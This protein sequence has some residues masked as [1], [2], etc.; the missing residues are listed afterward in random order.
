MAADSNFPGS[1]SR[2]EEIVLAALDLPPDRRAAYLQTSC[3]D[4]SEL[5][6][7]VESM[8]AQEE[9]AETF[10]EAPA[11]ESAARALASSASARIEGRIAGPYR[12]E[13][14]IGAGGMGEVYRAVDTRLGRAVAL[15]FLAGVFSTQPAAVERFAREARAASALNHPNICTVYDV[16]EIEGLPFIAMEYLEGSTLRELL[17]EDSTERQGLNCR[18]AVEIA[19]AVAAGLASAHAK[20]ITHRDLKPENIFLTDDGRV[21]ILDFGLAQ[22]GPLQSDGRPENT[23]GESTSS[24]AGIVMGTVAYM[25]PEQAEGKKV[26]PRSDVFSFGSVL[27][28]LLTGDRPFRGN[29]K[30]D[31]LAA[32]IQA[33]PPPMSKLAGS[34]PIA[35]QDLLLR[36]LNRDPDARFQSAGEILRELKNLEAAPARGRRRMILAGAIL[37]TAGIAAV[38]V[39]V[40]PGRREALPS[41]P[42][43]RSLA[44]L[45]LANLSGDPAQDYFADGITDVLIAD[46]AQISSLRVISRTSV[47]QFKGSRQ[48]LPEIGR[49]LNVDAVIEG[50]VLRSGDQVRVTAELVDA[51]SDRHLWARTYQRKIGDVLTLQGEVAGAIA[52]EIRARLT[53]QESARLS[54]SHPIA[55]AT[56]EAY[57][58]GR[59]YWG[60][61][62]QESLLKSVDY[63][64]QA[65]RLDPT[66]AAAFAGLA[67]AWIGLAWIEAMPWEQVDAN[68]RQAAAK[69]LSMDD[70]LGEAHAA[71]GALSLREWNWKKAEAEDLRA[72]ALNPG[73]AIAH[74]A[75]ANVL[76]YQGRADDSIAEAKRGVELDPLAMVTN[77][78][79]ADAYVSARR[80]DLA[81]AQC[82]RALELDP[83]QSALQY[84]LGWAYVYNGQY[85][86]GL[87]ALEKSL[88]LDR[89]PPE[90]SP[91][92]AYV[93]ILTGKRDEA[94]N[95]LKRLLALARKAPINPGLIALI[96]AGL[97][98][99]DQA[100]SWLEQA[101]QRHS[102]MMTWLKVDQR[103]DRI[104]PEPRFHELM[105]RVGLS[106]D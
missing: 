3:G 79:L 9:R 57:L 64:D 98:D 15:K 49:R 42:R 65:T 39:F 40:S 77:E 7:D 93:D 97:D 104:R 33:E 80:Y 13:A 46:L 44:V 63:Y 74:I 88:S 35:V 99:R 87:D 96:Y 85:E 53:P 23:G 28:E 22:I 55:P 78:V 45:P 83:N 25:S 30:T 50:T 106:N 12:I 6:R 47:M 17:G 95:I 52:A 34:V 102:P 4:N 86:Q 32:I 59:Y 21:K 10:L 103:F 29:T 105:R 82:R 14:L 11:L 61:F 71:M 5:R 2:I 100:L 68:A 94:L 91:D 75:Y 37:A 27:Y 84:A 43:L 70:S 16:G 8:L 69:A 18:Q 48:A 41:A 72:I 62:T 20:G 60:E 66:Y 89:V 81:I 67:E 36:C 90:L 101:Y 73:Y 24:E 19:G 26:D 31:T 76:R 1:R 38:L 51:A 56:L 54:R 92:L 58:K